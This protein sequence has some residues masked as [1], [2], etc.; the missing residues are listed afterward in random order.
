VQAERVVSSKEAETRLND[1][2]YWDGVSYYQSQERG[3]RRARA[4]PK[5]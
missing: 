1:A 3:L 4:A 2:T 5:L